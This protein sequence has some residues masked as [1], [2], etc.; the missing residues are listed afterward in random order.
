MQIRVSE[1]SGQPIYRQ[2]IRQVQMLVAS[3]R[4]NEGDQ[5]PS[6]RALAQQL[7]I[8]PN[9]VA[10]AYRDLEAAGTV[11]S[12]R[13]SGVFVAG[14]E[15]PLSRRERNRI[16][17]ERIDGLLAEASQLNIDVDTVIDMLQ[18]RHKQFNS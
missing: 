9:T 11:V 7:L 18:R 17:N 16:L 14:S 5:L 8:N 10:R 12:R 6:V 2:V 4:L 13:G 15:S 1:Q 3:G